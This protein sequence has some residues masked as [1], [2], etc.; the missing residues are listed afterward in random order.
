MTDN[1]GYSPPRPAMNVYTAML[2]LS[3]VAISIGCLVLALDM[4]QYE[5]K[6]EPPENLKAP[7]QEKSQMS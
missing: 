4:N 2:V 3:F 7:K 5:F 1:S 6:M